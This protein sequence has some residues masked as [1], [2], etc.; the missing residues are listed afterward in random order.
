LAAP[1]GAFTFAA[2]RTSAIRPSDDH[3]LIL[4]HPFAVHRQHVGMLNHDDLRMGQ[5]AGEKGG[6]DENAIHTADRIPNSG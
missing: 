3:R 4:Q 2:G 6:N 1:A 5:R